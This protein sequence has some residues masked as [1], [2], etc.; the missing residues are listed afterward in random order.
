M[1]IAP[2]VRAL[3][4]Y[5]PGEQPKDRSIVKL[6][7]NENPYPPSPLVEKTLA[8]FDVDRLRRYPDPVFTELRARIAEINGTT[9]A[10]VFVGNGS[11]EVLTLAARAF[12][13]DDEAIGSFDP[14]YSLYKTLA[15]IRNVPWVGSPLKDDFSWTDPVTAAPDGTPVSLFL[16][17]NP[18]APTSVRYPDGNVESFA[19]RFPGVVLV[20]EA[21][22]DFAGGNLMR[23]ATAPGNDTVVVMRTLSKSFSLA[24]LR[25]GYCVGPA[26]LIDALYKVKDSYNADAVAQAVALAALND[27]AWM[28]RNTAKITA[29]RERVADTLRAR[30]CDVPVSETNFLFVRPACRPAAEIFERLKGRHIYVRYFTGPKTGDRLRV[31]IGTEA[32]MTALLTAWEEFDK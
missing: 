2:S 20:D 5:V 31:S 15:A 1:K 3:D 14:S 27:L 22:A 6:N 30:G 7:T 28:K 32:D 16:L 11:D 4:P 21:Y 18:N 24:G 8:S 25:L 29:T 17:T 26:E 12:V 19:E 13:A 9:P 10:C 23:L